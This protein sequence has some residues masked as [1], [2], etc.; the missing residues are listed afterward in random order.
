MDENVNTYGMGWL[1]DLPDFRDY[2]VETDTIAE[3]KL[4]AGQT[5]SIKD[6]LAKMGVKK[7]ISESLGETIDLRAW[8]SPIENQGTLGSCTA[9][10]AVGLLEYFERRAYGK[11]I[12]GSRRFL[13]KVTRNFLGFVGDTGAYIR[14]TM[15]A[16]VLFGIPPEKY[17]PYNITEFDVE[18]SAFIYALGQ[19]YQAVS[20]YRLDPLGTTPSVLLARIKQ[21]LT[22]G[23]PSM[24]G[25]SV[26]SSIAQAGSAGNIPFPYTGDTIRGGHAVMAVGFDDAIEIKHSHPDASATTGAL[27]IRNSW[28][29]SWGANGYGWLPYDYVLRGLAVDWWSLLRC[30]WVDTGK[31]GK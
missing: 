6:M 25:F 30:E 18:P 3:Q 22:A 12:D 1:P 17:W 13:Y 7:T 26:Y 4:A 5:K 19:N 29:T 2:S 16:M 8:C 21:Y 14:S 9:N 15:G 10:A 20:Y 23:L 11:H 28:G 31:F 24:F 27:L